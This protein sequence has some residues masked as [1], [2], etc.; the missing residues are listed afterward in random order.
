MDSVIVY[1]FMCKNTIYTIET[2]FSSVELVYQVQYTHDA[3]ARA[4]R[5]EED[6][7]GRQVVGF[8]TGDTLLLAAVI[9]LRAH[10]AT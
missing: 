4:D 2:N 3:G 10:A 9:A 7:R 5:D 6:R 8:H 1:L